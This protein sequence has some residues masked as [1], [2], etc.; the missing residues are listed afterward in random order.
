MKKRLAIL[1]VA[2]VVL[3]GTY[4]VL[5]TVVLFACIAE[6]ARHPAVIGN[7]RASLFEQHGNPAMMAAKSVRS[8]DWCS[9]RCVASAR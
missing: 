3:V 6:I 1:V 5:N 2:V 4:L 7:W 9:G 8:G